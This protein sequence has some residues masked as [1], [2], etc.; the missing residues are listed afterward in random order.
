M[1]SPSA[2]S[3]PRRHARIIAAWLLV[4]CALVAAT[5]VVGGMTRL[6]GSGLSMVDWEPVS[7][8]VPPMS[9]EGWEREFA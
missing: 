5:L 4:G 8:V 9:A 2:Q 7:G 1:P 3:M 6:T